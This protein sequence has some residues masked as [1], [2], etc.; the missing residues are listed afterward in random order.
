MKQALLPAAVRIASLPGA[1]RIPP[2]MERLG[3]ALQSKCGGGTESLWQ[4]ISG[5]LRFIHRPNPVVLDVGANVGRWT[6]EMARRLPEFERIT[7]FEPQPACWPA[8]SFAA[9][10]IVLEKKAVSDRVGRVEFFAAAANTEIGS[11]HHR[12][13]FE[14]EERV[15]VETVTLDGYIGDG[16]VD[17]VKMDIEGHEM[18]ALKGAARA[19]SERRIGAISFEFGVSNVNSRTFFIDAWEP[20]TRH[21]YGIWRIRHDGQVEPIL[22]YSRDLEYFAGVANYVA[23]ARPPR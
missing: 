17:F 8:L 7:M 16:T 3:A 10:R 2:L 18:A 9:D 6:L 13:D 22:R 11:L 15:E 14:A 12:S 4:E 1:R 21:G 19:L 23:S 20:L 5:A